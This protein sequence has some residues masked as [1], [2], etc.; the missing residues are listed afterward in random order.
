MSLSELAI[1]NPARVVELSQDKGLPRVTE[2]GYYSSFG[3]I[4]LQVGEDSFWHDP[5]EGIP[6][7]QQLPDGIL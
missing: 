3:R 5:Y 2:E 4:T 7:F 6:S 1:A